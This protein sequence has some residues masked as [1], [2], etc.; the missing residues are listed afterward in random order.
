MPLSAPT[1]RDHCPPRALFAK[2]LR[3]IDDISQ[4]ITIRVHRHC[5]ESYKKDEEYFQATLVPLAPGSLAG[6]AIFEQFIAG[7]RKSNRKFR[8]GKKILREFERRPS[9]LH[10]PSGLTVK[11]FDRPRITRVLWKIARGL[12][13]HE[14]S[15]ILPESTSHSCTITSPGQR[16]PETFLYVSGLPDDETYGHYAGVFDY[17]FRSFE[18]DPHKIIYWS[19][20]IWDRIITE[21]WCHPGSCD[22]GVDIHF[23]TPYI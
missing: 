10:L 9:G 13:F 11:R 19:F 21:V 16:P 4:L 14:H 3:Q 1:S 20:L 23:L 8:L 15:A 5:N 18:A 17:R 12:C 7:T 6:N 22:A 2:K